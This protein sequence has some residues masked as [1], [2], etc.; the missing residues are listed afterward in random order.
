MHAFKALV[1]NYLGLDSHP[2]FEVVESYLRSGEA[3]TPAQVGEVLLRNRGDANLA[4]RDV[5]SAMQAKILGLGHGEGMECDDA[6]VEAG[7]LPESVLMVGSPESWMKKR[8]ESGGCGG[9]STWEK[10]V[11]FLVRLRSLTKSDS[12][13]RD[14]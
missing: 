4:L 6:A 3:L 11:K 9:G 5:V 10:K 12:G 1:K 8:K 2:V 14:V 7:K 13:K